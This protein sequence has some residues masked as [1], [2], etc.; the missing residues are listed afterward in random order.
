MLISLQENANRKEETLISAGITLSSAA[1]AASPLQELTPHFLQNRLQSLHW[2]TISFYSF[3][4]FSALRAGTCVLRSGGLRKLQYSTHAFSTKQNGKCYPSMW[5]CVSCPVPPPLSKVRPEQAQRSFMLQNIKRKTQVE[6][7]F[8][9]AFLGRRN[10]PNT[11]LSHLAA[12][13][14]FLFHEAQTTLSGPNKYCAMF[15][16]PIINCIIWP[17]LQKGRHKSTGQE[18]C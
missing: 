8:F 7:Y 12:F 5:N 13:S 11:E 9:N 16:V 18:S 1:P 15:H 2:L 3:S 6:R 10:L 17:I 14:D 4:L